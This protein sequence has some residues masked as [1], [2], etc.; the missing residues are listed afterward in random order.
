MPITVGGGI[1]T[2]EDATQ[3]IQAG[4]EKVSVN[5]AAVKNPGLISEIS[6]KFGRC[7]TALGIAA[8]TPAPEDATLLQRIRAHM[9]ETLASQPNYTCLETTARFDRLP[10]RR[11]KMKPFDTVRLEMAYTNHHEWYGSPGDRSFS[12]DDPVAFVGSGMIGAIT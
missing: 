11:A 10:G 4:A 7:A 2:L 12:K 9:M 1:R 5:S 3:L 6:K 8:Q